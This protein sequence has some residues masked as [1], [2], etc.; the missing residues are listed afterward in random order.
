M[1]TETL[2]HAHG[3][4]TATTVNRAGK[5]VGSLATALDSAFHENVCHTDVDRSCRKRCDYANDVAQFCKEYAQHKLFDTVPGRQHSAF[6]S[7]EAVMSISN[8]DK[9]K[10][11]LMKYSKKLDGLHYMAGHFKL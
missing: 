2:Q 11:R 10:A 6:P 4:Y 3:Q 7:F 9:L 5:I 1:C 8:P